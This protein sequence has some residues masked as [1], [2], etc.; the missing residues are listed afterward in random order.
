[1]KLQ[2]NYNNKNS[3]KTAS[4]LY[5]SY[6]NQSKKPILKNFAQKQGKV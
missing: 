3:K 5:N 4:K 6:E 2:I 1:M